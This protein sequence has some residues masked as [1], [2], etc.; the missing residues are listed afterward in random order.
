MRDVELLVFD[1]YDDLAGRLLPGAADGMPQ[2]KVLVHH[3]LDPKGARTLL[4]EPVG[5]PA[6]SPAGVKKLACRIDT[7]TNRVL[8]ART[9]LEKHLFTIEKSE[10]V[11]SLLHALRPTRATEPPVLDRDSHVLAWC[12]DPAR[13]SLLVQECLSLGCD[14]I[15]FS[16]LSARTQPHPILVRIDAPPWYLL[17]RWSRE[18]S[19]NAPVYVPVAKRFYVRW[20]WSHPLAGR[21]AVKDGELALAEADGPVNRVP[22][23]DWR[24]LY[25]A[26]AIEADGLT[27]VRWTSA[28]PAPRFTVK[29]KLVEAPEPVEPELWLLSREDLPAVERLLGLMPEADLKHLAIAFFAHAITPPVPGTVDEPVAAMREVITGRGRGW[30]SFAKTGFRALPGLPNLY[31]PTDQALD[32]QVRRDRIAEAF[33][34]KGGEFV[35]VRPVATRGGGMRALR[36]PESS[37]RPLSTYIDY[38]VTG[39][40]ARLQALVSATVFDPGP[41]AELAEAAPDPRESRRDPTGPR[42]AAASR[43]AQN[44]PAAVTTP[45]ATAPVEA[46]QVPTEDTAVAQEVS[47]EQQVEAAIALDPPG[48]PADWVALGELRRTRG[49]V[50]GAVECWENARWVERARDAELRRRS[51]GALE[52]ALQIGEATPAAQ[53]PAIVLAKADGAGDV[54]ALRLRTLY[55]EEGTAPD[56]TNQPA[57]FEALYGEARAAHAADRL[58]K[59]SR[60]LVWSA[61]LSRT[62]DDIEA[63]RQREAILAD[64]N[65]GGLAPLDRADFVRARLAERAVDG[66][67]SGELRR[68]MEGLT[69]RL[70]RIEDARIKWSGVALLARRWAEL[71]DVARARKLATDS[72][73]AVADGTTAASARIHANAAVALLRTRDPNGEAP[74]RKS[75]EIITRLANP[76]ERGRTLVAALESLSTVGDTRV[77]APLV[78]IA[79]DVLAADREDVRR[80]ALTI[81]RCAPALKKLA[82]TQRARTLALEY[83][84]DPKVQV[85][86]HYFA[87]AVGGLAALQGSRPLPANVLGPILDAVRRHQ[88]DLEEVNVRL[89][90]GAVTLAGEEFARE[91]SDT[92]KRTPPGEMR[93]AHLVTW[94]AALQGLAAARAS[95]AGLQDLDRA[96]K[97]AWSLPNEDERRRGVRRLTSVIPLFGRVTNGLAL[98]QDVVAR[99]GAPGVGPYFRSE[100]L[101]VCVDVAAR[102]GARQ[103]AF[104]VMNKV[105]Q[106]VES[107]ARSSAGDVTFLFDVL[108]L[109]VDHAVTIGAAGDSKSIIDRVVA[110]VE[111]WMD[112][113]SARFWTPFYRF[114]ALAK[115][116]RG[117]ARLGHEQTG[118]PILARILDHTPQTSGLDRIDLLREIVHCL[119]EVGGAQRLSLVDRVL[120]AYLTERSIGV[121]DAGTELLGMLLDEVVSPASRVRAEY[122]RYLGAE[123]RNI[124]ERVAN[125]RIIAS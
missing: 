82:A 37:F 89:F 55:L 23:T 116:A 115:C 83:A 36:L 62:G 17:E 81:A 22:D 5:H 9:I 102:L 66:N 35:V 104:E 57:Y 27:A 99:A 121:G 90:E 34:L 117:Y 1:G 110:L 80:R 52:G 31:L 13:F 68:T 73:G 18:G 63:E 20:G 118:M 120:E 54:R 51:I 42:P 39:D 100:V 56:V 79:L 60:W 112:E 43:N 64:L 44:E 45:Q 24:D 85:D 111:E 76:E 58:R 2:G 86:A 48:G 91:I 72:I 74:F 93:F 46:R 16:S 11:E 78:D 49:D 25:E 38:V 33:A 8:T 40:A 92:M 113:S 70:G 107:T 106:L 61:I 30:V 119:S 10:M 77:T 123:E 125:D 3:A 15:R 87:G 71:D 6:G 75:L 105:I 108:G 96:L 84:Q 94:A 88:R 95:D 98:V 67:D 7:A 103:G 12:A 41:L 69:E 53:R 122:A 47:N 124:R 4:V 50:D 14:R 32:P 109:C 59:K 21:L 97:V 26:L 65:Q 29:L 101:S 19:G 114:R 28:E